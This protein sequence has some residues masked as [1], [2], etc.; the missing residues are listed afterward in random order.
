MAAT[1]VGVAHDGTTDGYVDNKGLLLQVPD[2]VQI[3]TNTSPLNQLINLNSGN[4]L[5]IQMVSYDTNGVHWKTEDGKFTSAKSDSNTKYRKTD[6][7]E[8]TRG[9]GS[10]WFV[11]ST[12]Y[13]QSYSEWVNPIGS[14][15]VNVYTLRINR[16]NT[17]NIFIN[18][19]INENGRIPVPADFVSYINSMAASPLQLRRN[20]VGL[21]TAPE[22][23]V[24]FMIYNRELT[25]DE[26][27]NNYHFFQNQEPL[28]GISV[29][30][31]NV[32]LNTGENQRLSVQGLPNRYT[33][34]LNITYQSGNEGYVIVDENGILTGMNNGETIVSVT[35]TYEDQ[36]FTEYVNVKVGGQVTAP[37]FFL[38]SHR[39]DVN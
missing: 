35:A 37:S 8:G 28:E 27:R 21:N 39:R 17:A 5:T 15:A 3:P 7:S 38:K 19:A 12:G 33:E 34:L 26:V 10:F 22:T 29:N 9:I 20:N 31:S 25:D 2:Y 6:G 14:K 18:D 11:D 36:T 16:D 24:S 1:L 4:G 30:P 13:R 23:L 32:Q